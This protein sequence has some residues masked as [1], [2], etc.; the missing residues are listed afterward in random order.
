MLCRCSQQERVI[1]LG[2]WSSLRRIGSSGQS[3]LGLPKD[4]LGCVC[5]FYTVCVCICVFLSHHSK[6]NIMPFHFACAALGH[7]CLRCVF[8]YA[9]AWERHA[10]VHRCPGVCTA[11]VFLACH[12]TTASS[13]PAGSVTMTVDPRSPG[14]VSAITYA[15]GPL[16]PSRCLGNNAAISSLLRACHGALRDTL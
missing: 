9:P 4:S 8:A 6:N 14:P 12:L 3:C 7:A 10:S 13:R 15:L 1:A 5:V 16:E 11:C 2:V